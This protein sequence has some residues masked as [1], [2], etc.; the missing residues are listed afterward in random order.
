MLVIDVKWNHVTH[1]LI[2]T[3]FYYAGRMV[4]FDFSLASLEH[5]ENTEQTISPN[6]H[7]VRDK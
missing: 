4:P 6:G 7:G 5:T 3:S 2:V 1:S